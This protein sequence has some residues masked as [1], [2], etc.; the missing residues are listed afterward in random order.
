MALIF[1]EKQD[2][3]ENEEKGGNMGGRGYKIVI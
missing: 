2:L 3:A 1:S